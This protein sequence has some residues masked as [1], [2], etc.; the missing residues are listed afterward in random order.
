MIVPVWTVRAAEEDDDVPP[1]LN[2]GAED[3]LEE[4]GWKKASPKKT[5]KWTEEIRWDVFPE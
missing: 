3:N 4:R 1:K 5:F 2:P